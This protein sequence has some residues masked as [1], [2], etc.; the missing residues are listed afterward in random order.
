MDNPG[1]RRALDVGCGDGRHVKLLAECGYLVDGLD[2]REDTIAMAKELMKEYPQIQPRTNFICQNVMQYNPE[3]LYDV[4]VAW[5]Y[6]H[7]YNK[8]Y[9]ECELRV[10]NVSS[11]LKIGGYAFMQFST[12]DDEVY[13]QGIE[14]YGKGSQVYRHERINL[15]GYVFY[16][17]EEMV[18]V[19]T[20]CGFR[21]TKIENTIMYKTYEKP[22]DEEGNEWWKNREL[23]STTARF[24]VVAEKIS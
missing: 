5:N 6:F 18:D 19:M 13:K 24:L 16:N 1:N 12:K 14:L 22:K 11:L 20:R 23:D 10:K 15:D 3:S 2:I 8:T 17:K 4:I 7:A 9:E 21:I